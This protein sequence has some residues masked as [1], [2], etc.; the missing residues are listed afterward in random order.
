[1]NCISIPVNPDE[2]AFFLGNKIIGAEYS[3]LSDESIGRQ[4]TDVHHSIKIQFTPSKHIEKSLYHN[5]YSLK[6]PTIN[7]YR[8]TIKPTSHHD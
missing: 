1:M 6:C 8:I 2:N 5:L 4:A 7:S 3:S